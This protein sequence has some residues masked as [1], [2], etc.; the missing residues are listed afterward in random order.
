[1]EPTPPNLFLRQLYCYSS[2]CRASR[3]VS[4]TQLIQVVRRDYIAV[5]WKWSSVRRATR[6]SGWKRIW[7]LWVTFSF[8][9]VYHLG[10]G[11]RHL[12]HW[13]RAYLQALEDRAVHPRALAWAQPRLADSSE[14]R[15]SGECRGSCSR[16]RRLFGTWVEFPRNFAQFYDQPAHQPM[17]TQRKNVKLVTRHVRSTWK[18]TTR[19]TRKISTVTR[20]ARHVSSWNSRWNRLSFRNFTTKRIC[21]ST[22]QRHWKTSSSRI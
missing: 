16:H 12:V 17:P 20:K 22:C 2:I 4:L 13:S 18:T 7:K 5:E 15:Q 19:A 9:K 14:S 1:M 11:R 8:R 6:V 21:P 3:A 10:G